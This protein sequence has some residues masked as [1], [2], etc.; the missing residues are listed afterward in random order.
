MPMPP[1]IDSI[2]SRISL[3]NSAVEILFAATAAIQTDCNDSIPQSVVPI[4]TEKMMIIYPVR[5]SNSAINNLIGDAIFQGRT[6]E[7]HTR[8]HLVTAS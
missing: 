7:M 3:G 8:T 5:T 6:V 4:A 2:A 1:V